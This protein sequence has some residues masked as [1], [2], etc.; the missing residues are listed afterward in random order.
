MGILSK[1]DLLGGEK[2]KEDKR[3]TLRQI[4]YSENDIE[5]IEKQKQK[6]RALLLLAI[7]NWTIVIMMWMILLF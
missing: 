4:G 2:M 7:L 3:K 1:Y 5:Q 6:E